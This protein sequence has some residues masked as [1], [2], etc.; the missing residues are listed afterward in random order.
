MKPLA[1]PQFDAQY[2]A[3]TLSRAAEIKSNKGRHAA[4]LKHVVKKAKSLGRVLKEGK[5]AGVMIDPKS[6]ANLQTG[7]FPSLGGGS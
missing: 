3:D 6:A 1:M 5:G 7:S 4:A 2:D